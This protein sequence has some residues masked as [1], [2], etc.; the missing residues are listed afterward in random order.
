M[1]WPLLYLF[2]LPTVLW[3]G[4]YAHCGDEK[5]EVQRNEDTCPWSHLPCPSNSLHHFKGFFSES[6]TFH[7]LR[8]VMSPCQSPGGGEEQYYHVLTSRK[9]E[10]CTNGPKDYPCHRLTMSAT[11]EGFCLIHP[12]NPCTWLGGC[13]K[14]EALGVCV[15]RIPELTMAWP[16][17]PS[18][19]TVSRAWISIISAPQH[20]AQHLALSRW[21]LNI[22]QRHEW[23]SQW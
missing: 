8:S 18:M 11:E 22:Y 2:I 20:L 4:Y 14:W 10:I 19:A 21:S 1:F 6:D 15:Q 13:F 7:W 9:A 23:W 17:I 3:Q 16:P 5:T 12:W